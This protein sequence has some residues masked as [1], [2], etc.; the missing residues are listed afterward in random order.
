MKYRLFND[1]DKVWFRGD[2]DNIEDARK[3]AYRRKCLETLVCIRNERSVD[4]RYHAVG[5]VMNAKYN[6]YGVPIYISYNGEG[7]TNVLNPDGTL[8]RRLD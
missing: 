1:D 7:H 8:G 5:I 3:S 2:Y 6:K 4:L